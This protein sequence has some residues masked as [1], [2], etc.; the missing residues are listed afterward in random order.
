[1]RAMLLKLTAPALFAL[2]L[3]TAAC[4]GPPKQAEVADDTK[5][6]G[7][8]M[9]GAEASAE[10]QPSEGKPPPEAAEMHT[11]CCELCKE[12][13]AKDRTGASPSTIPCADF[14]DTLTP[15]CLEHFRSKPT[16]A[17]ACK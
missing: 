16:M 4:G 12:G 14:T 11:K 1:M 6:T 15:W 2:S 17:D 10:N 3:L 7:M 9:A 13:L 5:E 8:D